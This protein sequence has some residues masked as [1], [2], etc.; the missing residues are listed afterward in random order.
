V[1]FRALA[2][3]KL[4]AAPSR[5]IFDPRTGESWGRGD[6]DLNPELLA[7]LAVMDPPRP[8]AVLV[9]VVAHASLTVLL[10]KR[11]DS[12]STHA[13]QIAFPG[14]KV[15]PDD[16]DPV[17][18][19]LRE[20]REEIGLDPDFIEPLGF[21][22]SYRS[23]TGFHIMPLVALVWPGFT[24]SLDPS[25]VADAFEVPLSFLMDP[26][27]HQQHSREWRGRRRYYYAMPYGE[28]YIWG[29]T[30]G[31]IKNMH[32]RLFAA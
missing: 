21:L 7:D 4:R 22:D 28:H 9:P 19:A 1:E 27:H 16:A 3:C 29:A 8:A 26:R 30:A 17:A 11:T 10:T 20:A 18:T 5:A 15:E 25:E 24:L 23:G 14:G 32:E 6:F 13:G 2:R 31:M 12:L